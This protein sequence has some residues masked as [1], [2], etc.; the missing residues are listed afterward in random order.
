MAELVRACHAQDLK[1]IPWTVNTVTDMNQLIEQQ[2]DRIITDYPDLL[3][4]R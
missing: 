1:I 2:V 3:P 4:A